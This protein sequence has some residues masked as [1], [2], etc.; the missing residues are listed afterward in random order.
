MTVSFAWRTKLGGHIDSHNFVEF[1]Q[2][3]L[4]AIAA[5]NALRMVRRTTEESFFFSAIPINSTPQKAKI[6]ILFKNFAYF[7]QTSY[8]RHSI[9]L[10]SRSDQ[11]SRCDSVLSPENTVHRLHCRC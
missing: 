6:L 8:R 1:Q 7:S 10:N 2:F 5:N 4:S 3:I 9:P 11:G